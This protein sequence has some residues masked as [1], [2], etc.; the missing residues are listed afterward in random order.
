MTFRTL[1]LTLFSTIF[2][3]FLIVQPSYGLGFEVTYADDPDEGFFDSG[4]GEARRAAFEFALS[5]WADEIPSEATIS[6]TAKFDPLGGFPFGAT[7]AFAGANYFIEEGDAGTEDIPLIP[8]T[9]YTGSQ[10]SAMAGRSLGGGLPEFSV[11]CN[12]SVDGDFVLGEIVWYYGL[13]ENPPGGNVD[14]VTTVLHEIGHGLGFLDLID[15]T[16]GSWAFGVPDIYSR[17]LLQPGVGN[18]ETMTNRQRR[19]AVI[20]DNLFWKGDNVVQR[21]G[22]LVKMYAPNPYENGS[23]IAH[24]DTSNSPNLLMEPF[25]TGPS[26]DVDITREAF[27]DLGYP[28]GSEAPTFTP[29]SQFSPTP[30]RTFTATHTPTNTPTETFT[31]TITNTPTNTFTPT[32]TPTPT[33]TFTPR[34]T[35]SQQGVEVGANPVSLSS[36]D[37]DG[38]NFG[39]ILTA[40]RTGD[41]LSIVLNDGFGNFPSGGISVPVGEGSQPSF[42]TTGDLDN[43]GDSDILTIAAGTNQVISFL[44]T[45]DKGGVENSIQVGDKIYTRQEFGNL[46]VNNPISAF[47][48]DLNGDSLSDLAV[49]NSEGDDLTIVFGS[50]NTTTFFNA[51]GERVGT[52]GRLPVFVTGAVLVPAMPEIQ[53][54]VTNWEDSTLSVLAID[55]DADQNL[56]ADIDVYSVGVNPRHVIV[57]DFDTDG[58]NDL[59]VV[60][61]GAPQLNAPVDGSVS[62]FYNLNGSGQFDPVDADSILT[63]GGNLLSG[64]VFD[65]DKNGFVD[66]AISQRSLDGTEGHL[67]IYYN[68][69]VF[70]DVSGFDTFDPFDGPGIA[71]LAVASAALN[72]GLPPNEDVAISDDLLIT[73]QASNSVGVVTITGDLVK[74]RTTADL[75]FDRATDSADLFLF[76]L[77]GS[78]RDPLIRKTAD[79]SGEGTLDAEDLILFLQLQKAPLS[80]RLLY[81][82]STGGAKAISEPAAGSGDVNGD[83]VVD[84]ADF[85]TIFD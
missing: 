73:D 18:V 66:L 69:A 83:G 34:V 70:F 27:L 85:L 55:R 31:P 2:C 59:A 82:E 8:N 6:V 17:Q 42:V 12:S 51:V 81:R 56:V 67:L 24:W 65:F 25:D 19:I 39:D 26:H 11:T 80:P 22:D 35:H 76:A 4:L 57:A 68:D 3:G 62:L 61:Q 33:P 60:S 16:D 40:N 13:D 21:Q 32:N 7:L 53:L 44:Q 37:L 10:A 50:A 14:F 23:S 48:G 77:L 15:Q 49:A 38:E 46:S 75:N 43:D 29:T 20:S 63:P 5:I 78:Q 41:G 54:L 36:A 30:T 52:G 84:S 1:S 71:P 72:G 9:I 28:V 58:D 74:S 79:L 64:S 47:I 45:E